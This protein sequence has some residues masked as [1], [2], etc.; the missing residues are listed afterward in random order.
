MAVWGW[1]KRRKET[2]ASPEEPLTTSSFKSLAFVAEP[3]LQGAFLEG[4]GK[5][6][7]RWFLPLTDVSVVTI[8]TASDCPVVLDERFEGVQQVAPKHAKL[9][10]WQ[11]R[12]VLVPLERNAPVFVNG[13]RAGETALRDGTEIQLGSAGPK[14]LFRSES[15]RR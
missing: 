3:P 13:K 4:V 5:D 7:Q 2:E 11:N 8:G 9:E 6:G 1:L 15:G 10:R 14:F 12:W